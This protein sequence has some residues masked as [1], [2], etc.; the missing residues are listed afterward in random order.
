MATDPEPETLE[1]VSEEIIGKPF[2]DAG[3][4]EQAP[5]VLRSPDN[6]IETEMSI[7]RHEPTR[8]I[9]ASA[10]ISYLP[11]PDIV[12]DQVRLRESSGR[13]VQ[14]IADELTRTALKRSMFHW[15]RNARNPQRWVFGHNQKV[16]ILG[17]GRPWKIIEGV[18]HFADT[19][20]TGENDP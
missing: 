4:S 6:L 5:G 15:E 10:V 8:Q 12:M 14:S 2:K 13:S 1:K 18:V 17:R 19:D 16:R 7:N 20:L 11:N 9:I 3:W